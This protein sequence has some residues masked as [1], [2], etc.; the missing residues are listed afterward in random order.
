MFQ[1][2]NTETEV[3]FLASAICSWAQEMIDIEEGGEDGPK[4]RKV[5]PQIIVT[6][7]ATN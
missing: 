5:A 7:C 1:S 2:A 3:E 4:V 6:G